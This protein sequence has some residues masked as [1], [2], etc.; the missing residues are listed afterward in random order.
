MRTGHAAVPI[1]SGILYV[2]GLTSSGH[3]TN[4]VLHLNLLGL[5]PGIHHP[6][7]DLCTESM[8]SIKEVG[9]NDA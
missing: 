3:V 2:G 4:D 6:G 7:A 5:Y 9:V 8:Y 1:S